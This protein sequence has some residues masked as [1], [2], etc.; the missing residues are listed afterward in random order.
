MADPHNNDGLTAVILAGGQGTRL[1]P[2]TSALPKPLVPIGDHPIIE[3]LLHRLKKAGV[4]SVHIAVNHLAHLIEEVLGDGRRFG[5]SI[6]Y[7]REDTPLST[8]GPLTLLDNLPDH[9]LV[10]NG[11]IVTDLDLASFFASH[12]ASGCPLT[13]ATKTRTDRIDY[14]VLEI[15]ANHRVTSFREKPTVTHAVSMGIYCFSK[16]VLDHVPRGTKFGFDNLMLKLLA[17]GVPI[18]TVPYDGYWLDIGRPEDYEQALA[19]QDRILALLD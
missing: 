1:R 17:E 12:V 6:R 2:F 18:H 11:D 9:F 7:S 8:V 15:G 4:V 10:C 16:S 3:I 13:V 5:M 14:G 19:N